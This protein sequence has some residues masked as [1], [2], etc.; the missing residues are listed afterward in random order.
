MCTAT[1]TQDDDRYSLFFNRDELRTRSPALPPSHQEKDGIEFV[2]PTDTQAGGTWIAVNVY[3]QSLCLLND[4]RSTE[5]KPTSAL[6]SRG[7]LV[8]D[9]ARATDPEALRKLWMQVDYERFRPFKLLALA[10]GMPAC[11]FGWNGSEPSL[12]QGAVEPPLCSSSFDDLG[13]ARSRADLLGEFLDRTDLGSRKRQLRFHQSHLPE[14]GPYSVCMHRPDA[15]TVSLTLVD[16][17][18]ASVSMAY[19]HGAPCSTPLEYLV[20]LDRVV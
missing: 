8:A 16:V 11:L 13:A 15:A 19:A 2:A 9:M 20:A 10:P 18:A 17:D 5:S 1:W 3:G 12:E 7:L 6:T 14:R 4:Y